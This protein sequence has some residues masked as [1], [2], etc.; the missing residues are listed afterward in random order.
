MTSLIGTG[1]DHCM[2]TEHYSTNVCKTIQRNHDNIEK[3]SQAV[4]RFGEDG[5]T[6]VILGQSFNVAV[7][8]SLMERVKY[9]LSSGD[10]SR[11][12]INTVTDQQH[13][14]HLSGNYVNSGTKYS[15]VEDDGSNRHATLMH[16]L[17]PGGESSHDSCYDS[18][19][20][21]SPSRANS[22]Q[23]LDT[24]EYHSDVS[25]TTSD[26]L[27]A[28]LVDKDELKR[29]ASDH[30]VGFR[31]SVQPSSSSELSSN[32]EYSVKVEFA[33]KL[34]YTEEQIKSVLVKL[35]TS[36]DQNA[37]L[38]ELINLTRTGGEAAS[39][40]RTAGSSSNSSSTKSQLSSSGSQHL[41]TPLERKP[42]DLDHSGD[43]QSN[44]RAIVIDGSNV[45]MR[46]VH[47]IV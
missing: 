23:H 16:T 35:G 34:G 45:A 43:G 2:C 12:M 26:T 7:A 32:N 17:S 3:E 41:K 21:P 10:V 42:S 38:T 33:L 36:L 8:K 19:C 27:A 31:S 1:I 46:Y 39:I 9:S 22:M 37:L 24:S 6:I 15:S 47:F 11:L 4:L 18:D 20:S 25:R 40:S 30:V 44:L 14:H 28:E 29:S 13:H 5:S